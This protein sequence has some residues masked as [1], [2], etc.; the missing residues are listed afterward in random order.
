MDWRDPDCRSANNDRFVKKDQA[1][2]RELLSNY[3]RIGVLWFDIDGMPTMWDPPTTYA[4]VRELQPQIIINNRLE[5]GS[6]DEWSHQDKLLPNEDYLT[7]EQRIGAYNDK[8][9]WETCMTHRHAMVVEA[10]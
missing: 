1:E 6:F 7:P 5:M 8:V 9:P 10:G 3:G 2:L 4:L